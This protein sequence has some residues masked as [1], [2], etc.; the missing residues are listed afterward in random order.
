MQSRNARLSCLVA[1]L[2]PTNCR[3]QRRR[4]ARMQTPQQLV[5]QGSGEGFQGTHGQQLL[6]GYVDRVIPEPAPLR[7]AAP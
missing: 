1:Y 6:A 3:G 4:G 2:A 7:R 5:I